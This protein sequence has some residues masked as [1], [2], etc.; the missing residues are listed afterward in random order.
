M[1]NEEKEEED[2]KKRMRALASKLEKNKDIDTPLGEEQYEERRELNE[3][4][5]DLSIKMKKY[6]EVDSRYTSEYYQDLLGEY[7]KA[8]QRAISKINPQYRSEQSVVDFVFIIREM[9]LVI[10]DPKYPNKNDKFQEE[11]DSLYELIYEELKK[12]SP[13]LP[14]GVPNTISPEEIQD[15]KRII[16]TMTN[17]L[18][19]DKMPKDFSKSIGLIPSNSFGSLM[20]ISGIV[21]IVSIFFVLVMLLLLLNFL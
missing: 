5:R 7:E 1:E 15:K 13:F 4:L 20:K 11:I 19:A 17:I 6:K 12:P 16:W 9:N 3:E 10:N 2:Y 14:K 21:C 8:K 18:G